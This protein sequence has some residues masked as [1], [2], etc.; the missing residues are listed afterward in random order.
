[1]NVSE[2]IVSENCQMFQKKLFQNNL[3]RHLNV[4]EECPPANIDGL[5][6]AHVL[7]SV[8]SMADADIIDSYDNII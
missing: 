5:S 4:S 2:E 7:T 6:I 3:L 8:N 1:V